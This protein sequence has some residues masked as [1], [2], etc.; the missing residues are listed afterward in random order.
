MFRYFPHT[1]PAGYISRSAVA[2]SKRQCQCSSRPNFDSDGQFAILN[3][4]TNSHSQE[5][6]PPDRETLYDLIVVLI[7]FRLLG[8]RAGGFFLVDL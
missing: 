5:Q 1:P 4:Y 2:E 3:G 8:M 7:A 6:V